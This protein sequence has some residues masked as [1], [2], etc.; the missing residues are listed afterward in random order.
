MKFVDWERRPAITDDGFA[1]AVLEPGGSWEEVDSA[2]V[3]DSG[4]LLASEADMR[5]T[6]SRT[7]GRLPPLPTAGEARLKSEGGQTSSSDR[8][9]LMLSHRRD[10]EFIVRN[11]PAQNKALLSMIFSYDWRC[12]FD[13]TQEPNL[14]FSNQ[15]GNSTQVPFRLPLICCKGQAGS[16]RP[17]SYQP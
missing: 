9:A 17:S 1:W 2:E 8:D 5:L 6:F 3:G 10:F 15:Q 14:F 7:F 12:F 11:W 13:A 16:R 4:R